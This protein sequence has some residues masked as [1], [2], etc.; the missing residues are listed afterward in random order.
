[1]VAPEHQ[2][3]YLELQQ[4]ILLVVAGVDIV[5]MGLIQLLVELELLE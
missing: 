1:M 2:I 4:L 5:Q 3:Q